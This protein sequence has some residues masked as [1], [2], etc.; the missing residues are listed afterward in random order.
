MKEREQKNSIKGTCPQ[1]NRTESEGYAGGQTYIGITENN[2]TDTDQLGYGLLEFIV[3][4]SNLNTA[5][6]QVKRN[7]EAGGIDKMEVESLKDYLVGHKD[8]L[9]AAIQKGNHNDAF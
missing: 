9:I 4:P 2:L 1:K 6:R 7:K 3:S 5:Y 8:E